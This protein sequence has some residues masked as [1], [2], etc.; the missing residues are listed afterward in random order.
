MSDGPHRSLP[1]S[2]SWKRFAGQV[3]NPAVSTE[4]AREALQAA[5]EEDWRSEVPISLFQKIRV[6]LS[7]SQ[8]QLFQ[9]MVPERLQLLQAE[10]AG[11]LLGDRLVGQAI[12]VVEK[13]QSGDTALREATREALVER[14]QSGARQVEEHYYRSSKQGELEVRERIERVFSELDVSAL[15]RR[16]CETEKGEHLQ[17][18]AK[19]TGL[20]DGVRL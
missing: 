10:A 5:L 16:L 7:D 17:K 11:H 20:D 8:G 3:Y 6:T 12:R 9:D 2:P 1:M 19:R 13:G 15:A 18:P 4:E 14:A